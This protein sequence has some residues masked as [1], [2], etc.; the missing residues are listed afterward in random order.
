MEG[1]SSELSSFYWF[2]ENNPDNTSDPTLTKTGS[3]ISVKGYTLKST[4]MYYVPSVDDVDK[5]LCLVCVPR[6]NT[7]S[8]IPAQCCPLETIE[9]ID[10]E[11]WMWS[12]RHNL[13]ATVAPNN[14]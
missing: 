8:G 7:V 9:Q 6:G 2:V 4:D 13:C 3:K 1:A 14:V 5:R 10:D 11:E 12:E